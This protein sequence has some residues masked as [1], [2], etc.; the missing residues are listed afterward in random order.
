MGKK[1]AK[2]QSFRGLASSGKLHVP[3]CPWG[4]RLV[5]Q[6]CVFPGRA[7]DDGVDVCSGF[8]RGLDEMSWSSAKI[9]VMPKRGLKFGSWEWLCAGSEPPKPKR[10]RV[11]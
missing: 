6:L 4:E 1:V 2:F 9:P 5:N 11:Y 10:Q 3:R 8:G 7:H